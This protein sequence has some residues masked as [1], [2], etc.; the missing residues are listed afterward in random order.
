M[1]FWVFLDQE[2]KK[3][4]RIF[5]ISTLSFAE[6]QKNRAKQNKFSDQK[7]FYLGILGCKFENVL[8]YFLASSNL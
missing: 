2:L 7:C 6:M 5:G 1:S 3:T 8:S 4:I